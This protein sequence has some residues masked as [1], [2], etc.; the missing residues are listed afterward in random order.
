MYLNDYSAFRTQE[1]AE[2]K[3]NHLRQQSAH[4]A[5]RATACARCGSVGA[6]TE[7]PRGGGLHSSASA[8][9]KSCSDA[10]VQGTSCSDVFGGHTRECR[11]VYAT[12]NTQ[13]AE[14]ALKPANEGKEGFE[15]IEITRKTRKTHRNIVH[16]E[17]AFF[18]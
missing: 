15:Q 2:H 13:G 6:A 16:M 3:T 11:R 10:C 7:H 9:G 12:L 17:T 8:R 18:G 4:T 14:E 5:L 1:H